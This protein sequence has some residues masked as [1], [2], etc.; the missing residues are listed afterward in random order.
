MTTQRLVDDGLEKA[1]RGVRVMDERGS[2]GEPVD[3]VVSGGRVLRLGPGA[4]AGLPF[5]DASERWLM[6]GIVDCHTHLGC[7][8]TST[9]EILSMSVTRWTLEVARNAAKVLDM[10]ITTI[11]DPATADSGI[12]DAIMTGAV[13]GP[14]IQVSGGALSQTGGH[15]D[16]FV[17]ILGLECSSGFMIPDYPGRVEHCVDGPEEVR[18]AVRRFARAGVDWIKICTTGGLLSTMPDH[19]DK[20]EFTVEEIQMAAE[21]AARARIPVCVHAY[22]GVGLDRAVAAG[23]RSIEHGLYLTEAQ[24]AAMAKNDCWLVPTLAVCEELVRLADSAQIPPPVVAKVREIEG[25]IGRQVEIARSAG[26]RIAMGSDLV[27]QGTNLHE[28]DLLAQAGMPPEEV[29]VAAT[30][31]GAELL[32]LERTHGRIAPGYVFDAVLLDDDPRDTSIFRNERPVSA[33][34]QGGRVVR[35][36]DTWDTTGFANRTLEGIR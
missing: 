16:G 35:P 10:G 7:F 14:T 30:S 15:V 28:L 32:G 5:Y 27:V 26:V 11:R 3:V 31:G 17:P 36:H 20:P 8:T 9:D 23:V 18:R 21:E 29:L 2:F 4:G 13:P 24:A 12:R 33:V 1:V 34:F 25:V 22:G 6:P 19:P